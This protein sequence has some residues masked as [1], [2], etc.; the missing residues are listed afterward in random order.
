MIIPNVT[1]EIFYYLCRQNTISMYNLDQLYDITGSSSKHEI[2]N[3]NIACS[4]NDAKRTLLTNNM[5][6]SFNGYTF[7][8]ILTG[9]LHLISGS[10]ELTFTQDEMYVYYPGS[11]VTVTSVS[12]DYR[13]IC[14]KIDTSAAYD[15]QAFRN[16]LRATIIPVSKFG[17]SKMSFNVQ[18]ASRLRKI[19]ELVYEYIHQPISLKSE[20]L[21]MLTS[22]F[23]NDLISIQAFEKT[24]LDISR[25]TEEIFISFYSLLQEHFITEHGIKFYANRL[26]ITE[27]Y[28]SR[29]IKKITGRTV[30]G[31]I[32]AMLAI[33]ATW[34]IKTTDLTVAQIADKLN[35]STS[36][37]LDKFYKRMRG[38]TPLSLRE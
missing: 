15:T 36:A 17:K 22:I 26:H 10:Q 35:F 13:G 12:D 20:I 38:C 11:A 28:L 27:N 2:W 14:L 4:F 1:N 7:T 32:D 19:M 34:L 37:A 9:E 30:V 24:R 5:A 29:I 6:Q 23:I 33:E 25:R 21:E 16:L 3:G 8:L 18:D 31:C